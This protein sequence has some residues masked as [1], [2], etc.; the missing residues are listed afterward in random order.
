MAPVRV[1]HFRNA[2]KLLFLS[3]ESILLTV[4]FMQVNSFVLVLLTIQPDHDTALFHVVVIFFFNCLV[5]ILTA[6]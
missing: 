3:V 1:S 2:D 4:H 6:E 5:M